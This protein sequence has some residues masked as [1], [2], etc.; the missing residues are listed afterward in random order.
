VANALHKNLEKLKKIQN[1]PQRELEICC[2]RPRGIWGRRSS[3][4]PGSSGSSGGS[5]SRSRGGSGFGGGAGSGSSGIAG[6]VIPDG[7]MQAMLEMQRQMMD[8]KN[9]L[10]RLR[11]AVGHDSGHLSDDL[12]PLTLQEK[13]DLIAHISLLP[14]GCMENLVQIVQQS[15]PERGNIDTDEIEIPL[16]ELDNVTLRRLQA[17]VS[18]ARKRQNGGIGG[19]GHSGN[20]TT[21]NKR[22]RT[23]SSGA[24]GN[25]EDNATAFDHSSTELPQYQPQYQRPDSLH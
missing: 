15:A 5:N 20:G 9:E 8:M 19:V 22:S 17:Y 16:D 24:G 1:F 18:D 4:A 12:R 10:E 23:S 11:N 2:R 7:S 6:G 21:S 13:K 25:F 3:G 14:Q